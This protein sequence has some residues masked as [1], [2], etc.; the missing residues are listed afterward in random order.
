MSE[1]QRCHYEEMKQERK[2]PYCFTFNLQ[3]KQEYSN[4]TESSVA[5]PTFLE[6]SAS[7]LKSKDPTLDLPLE[8]TEHSASP[9]TFT[10]SVI[11]DQTVSVPLKE[12]DMIFDLESKTASKHISNEFYVYPDIEVV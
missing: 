8:D 9:I 10:V 7:L 4:E 11:R 5:K 2:E 3:A 1:I 12:E 6:E